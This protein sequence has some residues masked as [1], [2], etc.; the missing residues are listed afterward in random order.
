MTD[1]SAMSPNELALLMLFMKSTTLI[2]LGRIC[3]NGFKLLPQ[4][5]SCELSDGHLEQPWAGGRVGE[6]V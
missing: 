1:I 5:Q 3:K 2:L 4:Q 6:V